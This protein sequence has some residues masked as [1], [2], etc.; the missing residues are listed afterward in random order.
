M[1]RAIYKPF[2]SCRRQ[3]SI[4]EIVVR[5]GPISTM[6]LSFSE[7]PCGLRL[8]L[9]KTCSASVRAARR[10]PR[11]AR[12]EASAATFPLELVRAVWPSRPS[13]LLPAQPAEKFLQAIPRFGRAGLHPCHQHAV[14]VCDRIEERR[15]GYGRLSVALFEFQLTATDFLDTLPPR[16][17]NSAGRCRRCSLS[18]SSGRKRHNRRAH[19]LG[20]RRT[21][22][23][24][25]TTL[26]RAPNNP[27]LSSRQ[28]RH[29][30]NSRCMCRDHCKSFGWSSH[31]P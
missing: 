24:H 13:V 31:N 26:L 3:R 7:H 27:P 6:K 30:C 10:R 23:N 22:Q 17:G 29:K 12:V 8:L 16:R 9:G 28:R 2:L 18:R 14:P 5:D 25:Y 4:H 19:V 11:R 15:R 1:F 20:S 21:P